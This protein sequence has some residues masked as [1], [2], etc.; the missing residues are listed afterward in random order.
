ML[1][2]K[3]RPT[4][5]LGCLSCVSPGSLPGITASGNCRGP[6]NPLFRPLEAA[7]AAA[8]MYRYW[9][10]WVSS[11][12]ISP[13]RTPEKGERCFMSQKAHSGNA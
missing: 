9:W 10:A 7:A 11:R 4:P 8:V 6:T 13:L 12:C 2:R 3:T 1:P 5:N